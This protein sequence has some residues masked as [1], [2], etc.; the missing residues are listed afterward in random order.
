MDPSLNRTDFLKK[1]DYLIDQQVAALKS[2]L[3]SL[4]ANQAINQ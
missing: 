4:R 3:T 2:Q 1:A